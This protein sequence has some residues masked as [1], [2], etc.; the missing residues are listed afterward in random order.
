MACGPSTLSEAQGVSL[1]PFVRE[2]GKA[3]DKTTF[4]Q[5]RD[6]MVQDVRA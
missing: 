4:I 6:L 3:L 2:Y 1:D 5:F